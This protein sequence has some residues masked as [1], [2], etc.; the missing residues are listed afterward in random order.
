MMRALLI[1]INLVTKFEVLIVSPT[2]N[3]IGPKNL[4]MDHMTL[5]M[6]DG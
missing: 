2:R 1:D 6:T 3:M 4:K 5:T